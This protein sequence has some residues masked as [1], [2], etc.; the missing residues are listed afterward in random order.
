MLAVLGAALRLWQ[1]A[2][3]SSLWID[4]LAL[5]RNIIDRSAAVLF[6]PLDYAQVAPIGFLLAEKAVTLVFGTNEYALRALPLASGMA[7]L[8]LFW[9]LAKRV[10]SGWAIPFA[11][12]LFSLGIPFIYLSSQVKQYSSD[13]AAALFLTL[14]SLEVYRRGVSTRRAIWL[15]L[16]GAVVA[17]FSQPALFVMT[18]IGAGLLVLAA[19]RGDRGAW[20]SSSII[21]AGWGASAGAVAARAIRTVPELD[22]EYFRW[23]WAGG[24]MPLPPQSLSDMFWLPGKFMWVFGKFQLGLGRTDGGLGYR[25]SPVFALAMA[26]GFWVLWKK[27]RDA[28]LFLFLPTLVVV[29]LSGAEIY[30]L[31]ARLLAFLIPFLLVAVAAGASDLVTRL[32]YRFQFV[33]TGLLAVLIGAP[34]YAIATALPPSS[35]QH[36]RPIMAH[37]SERHETSDR[38]YVYSGAGLA[39]SYYAPRFGIPEEGVILGRCSLSDPR[40][41]LRELDLLRGHKRVWLVATHEQRDGELQLI[42]GYLDQLGRR[43]DSV[44]ERA[45][46]G[47][48]IE[49]AYGYLYDLSDPERLASVSAENYALPVTFEPIPEAA[50][51][52]GCHGITGGAPTGQP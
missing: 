31:T 10:L 18:G 20:Q 28:A 38:V 32:Q 8:V 19:M 1:Y 2:A 34:I 11:V 6:A 23:F 26:W 17:W 12:G 25:W 9:A 5:T 41:Y 47:R 7:S 13:V 46:S 29:G 52:W 42:L 3:N 15:G 4:E 40:S 30:P 45:T 16:A 33:G 22:R 50:A 44:I 51:R 35:I 14:T 21:W 36:V 49:H 39:F 43:L 24:F 48:P 37:V 27:Q